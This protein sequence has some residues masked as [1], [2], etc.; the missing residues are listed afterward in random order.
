[1]KKILIVGATSAIATAC[2]RRWAAEKS[3]FFLVARDPAKLEQLA[4]GDFDGDGVDD[5][6]R[7]T[8]GGWYVTYGTADRSRWGA[9]T[10]LASSNVRQDALAFADVNGDRQTDAVF[11]T[12]VDGAPSSRRVGF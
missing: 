3:A 9:W 1:M 4:T 2:A 11:Q 6:F 7:S 10:R 12:D 5:V 8:G